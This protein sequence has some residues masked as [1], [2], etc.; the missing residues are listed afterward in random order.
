MKRLRPIWVLVALPMAFAVIMVVIGGWCGFWGQRVT[1]AFAGA[2]LL[3]GLVM[4]LPLYV[5]IVWAES[6]EA[7]PPDTQRV[8]G[9]YSRINWYVSLAMMFGL[10]LFLGACFTSRASV[11]QLVACAL[12]FSGAAIK[13]ALFSRLG[14]LRSLGRDR[15]SSSVEADAP[16]ASP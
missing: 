6:P 5:T 7:L 2:L 3:G 16:E 4:A 11:V 8:Y 15:P 14:H 9:R 12:V 13:M 10:G 1:P